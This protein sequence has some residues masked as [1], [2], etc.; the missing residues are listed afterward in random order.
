MPVLRVGRDALGEGVRQR[1]CH[2]RHVGVRHGRVDAHTPA[3]RVEPESG[4]QQRRPGPQREGGRPRRH[5]GR[6]PEEG[7]RNAVRGQITIGQ[8][9]HRATRVQTVRQQIKR[10][11]LTTGERDDLHAERGAEPHEPIEQRGRFHPF[12]DRRERLPVRGQPRAGMFP[13]AHVRQRGDGAPARRQGR[14]QPR[15][16]QH[17]HA[18]DDP[19]TRHVLQAEDLQPVAGVG[20]HRGP[21][22]LVKVGAGRDGSRQV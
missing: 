8:Q 3:G 21:G 19:V 12:R 7:D 10:W 11:L 1:L 2:A 17:A 18:V 14:P 20:T 13:V 16:R 4:R 15:L 6:R 22:E 9:A 5:R